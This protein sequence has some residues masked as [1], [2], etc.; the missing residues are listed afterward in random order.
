MRRYLKKDY[1]IYI[2]VKIASFIV[3]LMPLGLVL[4]IGRLIGLSMYHLHPKRK[5]IAYANLKAAFCKEKAPSELK[6]ILKRTY[7]NYGQ[8]IIETVRM[9]RINYDYLKR[10][11][12][13]ENIDRIS[14]A[15][16][17]GK[18]IVFLTSHF[19]NWELSSLK[20][21]QAGYPIYVLARPQR[22]EIVN[23]LLNSYRER[24]GCKV[25]NRGMSSRE[26]VR[27]L[28]RNEIIGIL[29]DQDVGKEGIFI[30]LL[31]RPASQPVGAV[32]LARETGATI[33][34]TFIIRKNGPRHVIKLE[35]LIHVSKT[36]DR[37]GD[38]KSGLQRHTRILESYITQYPD[39]WMWVYTRWKS[40]PSR[41]VVIL[42]DGKRG[43]LN[44]SLAAF[45]II[46]RCRRD[47]GYSDEDTSCQ[48]I[49]VKFKSRLRRFILLLCSIFASH[50][51]QGCMGY[52]R[53]CL[54][55]D[56]YNNIMRT[57]ADIV[58][59]CGSS[60]S[61]VNIFLSKE[62]NSKNVVIMKPGIMGALRDFDVAIIPRHDRPR[63]KDNVVITEGS[64]N[65]IDEETMKDG[66]MK[67]RNMAALG[68]K[69]RL[70]L[71]IGG[72]NPE[73]GLTP[74]LINKLIGQVEKALEELD[75]ELLATTS[76]RTP[77]D[78]EGLL[79]ERL[80]RNPRC[81]LLIIANERNIDNAV[82]GILG[83]SD[84]IL[85]SGESISM[86]SEAA[87]SGKHTITFNLERRRPSSKHDYAIEGLASAD[88]IVQTSVDKIRDA[89]VDIS[90]NKR[91]VK[92]LDNA[93][94]MYEKLYRII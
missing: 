83:L 42:N 29:S 20:S 1:A 14:E 38:I 45:N 72:D 94:K 66:G 12:E 22:L 49:D 84:I 56:S 2:A 27:A 4:W 7:K 76:R 77:K 33:L 61:A 75:M 68:Q 85:V 37:D 23:D 79:K 88:Y 30:D 39:Q 46:K 78:A 91:P 24:L 87:S 62:N 54:D 35:E 25:V 52:L 82:G 80:G 6:G 3:S 19:G 41:R 21:A 71:L 43:H 10:Y 69:K 53:F 34:P 40:T 64:P 74:G 59:S 9:P 47:T 8:S 89:I 57:Y 60:L 36:N 16:K 73:Y 11:I 18:G 44:Q 67:I 32:R 50:A 17:R 15:K 13:V 81:K 55:K 26:I 93:E 63:E 92:R 58:I 31:G 90:C 51:C 65:L 5:R 48:I 86:V 28:K 70:G